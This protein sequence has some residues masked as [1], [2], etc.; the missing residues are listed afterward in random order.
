MAATNLNPTPLVVIAGPTASG[1]TALAIRLAERYDGEIICADSRTIYK[2]MDI[3]TAKPSAEEQAR[4]PHWGLD[5]VEPG[6]RFT[7]A[8][9]KAYA[10]RKIQEIRERGRIP[11]LVGGTGLYI[12]AVIFDFQLAPV[13]DK[14]L[15]TQLS[16]MD[17]EDLQDYCI[18][19]NISLP[20][21]K[22][23]KRYLVRAIERKNISTMR[24]DVP[25][26]NT[27]VVGITTYRETLR[28][29]IEHRSEQLFTNNV[30]EEAT[31]L[32]EKYGWNS[33]AMTGNIY[34]LVK[35]Y[36]DRAITESVLRRQ[37]AVSDWR[38]A[39]RQMTWLR[40]N[41]YITWGTLETTEHWLSNA[42]ASVR[43]LCYNV[44]RE[45]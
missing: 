23:N 12:D 44:P 17:V 39:K 1:K 45:E 31:I 10:E 14:T 19:N 16:L 4:V 32:G 11:F 25:L 29:R 15:R 40:R 24:R 2:G 13:P 7:V 33:E 18:K 36:V 22:Q 26:D 41:P 43:H 42:L 27:Y 21:N 3:G 5:I 8:D 37:S 35:K 9:F 6:E 30:V 28:T 38:L 20:E 34:P